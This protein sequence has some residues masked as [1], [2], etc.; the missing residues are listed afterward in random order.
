MT[1]PIGLTL[2]QIDLGA[3]DA[4]SDHRLSEY[5][6]KTPYVESAL[7]TRGRHFI[8]R[9]GSGKS[10]LFSQLPRLIREAGFT[11]TQV[12]QL[13]PDQYCW[14]ALRQ[15]REQG[16]TL[17]H[18]HTNAWKLTIALAVAS[19]LAQVDDNLLLG[20]ENAIKSRNHL[21]QFIEKNFDS[22]NPGLY[23][24]A[25]RIMKGLKSFDLSIL[26]FGVGF[27]Y[28]ADSQPLMP[29]VTETLLDMI[30]DVCSEVGVIVAFDKLD[31]SWDGTNE[32]QN[33]LIGLLKASKHITDRLRSSD[34]SSGLGVLT[35]L[36]TDIYEELR[37]DDKDKHRAMEE[38]IT[39]NPE[40]L[41]EMVK[42]RLPENVKVEDLFERG[43]MRGSISPFNYIVKRTFLRPRE[44]LQFLQ[45][46]IRRAGSKAKEITKDNIREAEERYSAWKVEDL[47]QEYRRVYPEFEPLLEALRQ[48]VHRY[49]SIKEFEEYVE[50]KAPKV[51][52]DLGPRKAV[53]ILFNASVIGVRLGNS[54]SPRFRCEDGNLILPASGAVYVHQSLYRGLHI[55]ERRA[56]E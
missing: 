22:T 6:V 43:E 23:A 1:L 36:R 33:L 4:E 11:K 50:Q 55:R 21:R 9:K 7:S 17:E 46:C 49:D 39:W 27:S 44:V 56:R 2:G 37:F 15:Y 32:S 42:Q 40:L 52:R 24:T 30:G 53:E 5:F 35:F 26:G 25:S 45:E 12:L 19:V 14:N 54:G 10:A 51:V 13:T 47:K 16:L 20:S 28:E 41:K 34:P 8:G 3:V 31:D 38:H 48:G 29:T 18:A